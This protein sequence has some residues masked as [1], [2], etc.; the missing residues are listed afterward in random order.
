VLG[1]ETFPLCSATSRSVQARGDKQGKGCSYTLNASP[2]ARALLGRGRGRLQGFTGEVWERHSR[3][4]GVAIQ[5]TFAPE[6]HP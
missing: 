3:Y 5:E 1:S 6:I 2:E 4:R